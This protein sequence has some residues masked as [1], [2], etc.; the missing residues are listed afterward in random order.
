M[1]RKGWGGRITVDCT[2]KGGYV[3]VGVWIGRDVR[4]GIRCLLSLQMT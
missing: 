4:D 3:G 1:D 2:A